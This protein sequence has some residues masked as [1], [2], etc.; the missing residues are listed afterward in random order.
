MTA[1][2]QGK[3][4]QD[5]RAIA[6][7]IALRQ[8]ATMIDSDGGQLDVV[9]TDISKDGF[10]L[11]AG[12]TLIVGEQVRLRVPRREEYLAEIKWARGL[13]AGGVFLKPGGG[14]R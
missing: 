13:E 11:E 12:E 14:V 7:R 3:R 1:D 4:E 6:P 2:Y 8:P 10:R 9:L 5:C